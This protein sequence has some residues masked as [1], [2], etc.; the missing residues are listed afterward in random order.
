MFT[1]SLYSEYSHR[2]PT[3]RC[4]PMS[5][6]RKGYWIA[7]LRQIIKSFR[8]V[9]WDWKRFRALSLALPYP[10][11]LPIDRKHGGVAFEDIVID[12]LGSIFY[13]LTPSERKRRIWLFF[14]SVYYDPYTNSWFPTWKPVRFCHASNASLPAE[15]VLEKSSLTMAAHLLRQPNG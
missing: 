10:G 4:V 8:S 7:T 15:D 14:S 13:K 1:E 3:W 9:C 2:D 11:P 5:A 12:F 6:V